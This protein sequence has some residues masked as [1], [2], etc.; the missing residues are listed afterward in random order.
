[1]QHRGRYD[2]FATY[3]RLR[4][5]GC[6]GSHSYLHITKDRAEIGWAPIHHLRIMPEEFGP[7]W[8]TRVAAIADDAAREGRKAFGYVGFDAMD[9]ESPTRPDGTPGAPPLA[10]FIVPGEMVTFTGDEQ[11]TH[12]SG[13]GFDVRPFLTMKLPLRRATP[14]D[15][16]LE[17]VSATPADVFKDGVRDAVAGLK[18][19]RA[20]KTVLS[21][22]Q[23]FD[24]AY[25]PAALFA[26]HCLARASVDAFLVSFG[27]VTAVVASPELLLDAADRQIV[28][29]PLAGTRPRG[30]TFEEDERLREELKRD[31]KEIIEHILSVS[32][33]LEQLEPLCEHDSLIV[34]RLMEICIQQ[35]VQHLSSVI[36][37][38][39]SRGSH[40]LDALWALVPSVTIAGFPTEPA[41]RMVRELEPGPRGLYSGIMGSVSGDAECRFS[42][43]IRGIFRYGERTFLHAGAGIVPG[44]V[45]ENEFAETE[46]KLAIT[47]ESLATVAAEHAATAPA[48]PA[49]IPVPALVGD[50]SLLAAR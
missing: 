47:R 49:K 17:P 32:T 39:L 19:G 4:D 33:M 20:Q 42:L 14:R 34:N 6:L 25:D 5:S 27:E 8:R 12:V 9:G 48:P 35:N 18:A 22:W 40:V 26:T 45:P 43:A 41:V 2:A 44:S 13:S 1:M 38:T 37:G 10:E 30:A 16:P 46:H 15:F 50:E 36:R 24:L 11:V 29:N 3:V 7:D 28:T 21:R 23:A 31:H